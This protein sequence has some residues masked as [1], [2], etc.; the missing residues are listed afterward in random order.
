[1]QSDICLLQR[2]N[3]WRK[4]AEDGYLRVTKEG[5]TEVGEGQGSLRINVLQ[6]SL[7]EQEWEKRIVKIQ[8]NWLGKHRYK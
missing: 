3:C 7:E 6:W 2:R 1:M 4:N 8:R 5:Q